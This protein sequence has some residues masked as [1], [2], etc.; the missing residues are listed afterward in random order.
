MQTPEGG[1]SQAGFQ[2]SASAAHDRRSEA[3]ESG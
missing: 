2:G 3:D 1:G